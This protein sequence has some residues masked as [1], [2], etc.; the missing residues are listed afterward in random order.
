M[1]GYV[2]TIRSKDPNHMSQNFYIGSTK[3]I[4]K[5]EQTH[6]SICNNN[7]HPHYNFKVY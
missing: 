4:K 7:G 1:I 3:D 2:Y 6:K 5:R